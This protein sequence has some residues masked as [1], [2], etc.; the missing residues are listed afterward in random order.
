[1]MN[2]FKTLKTDKSF[3]LESLKRPPWKLRF[4][5]R[6]E[7][8]TAPPPRRVGKELQQHTDALTPDLSPTICRGGRRR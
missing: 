3:F 1:M 8:V 4:P 5:K 7:G 2:N 6:P